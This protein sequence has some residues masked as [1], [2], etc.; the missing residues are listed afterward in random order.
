MSQLLVNLAF[1]PTKPTGHAIYA[2]NLLPA[3]KSLNP[4]LLTPQT[5]P[6]FT[7]QAIPAD[8]NPD[9]GTKGHFKRLL[10]EQFRLPR[11]YR[12]LR[13]TLLFSPIPEAPLFSRCR[14]VV[15]LH[16]L[17]PLRFPRKS[18]LT[19]YFRYYIPQV[20]K[21]AQ[22]VLCDSQAT[23]EDAMHYYQMPAQKFSVVPL[24]YDMQHFQPL[25]LPLQNYFL[26]IGRHDAY[27]NLERSLAAFATLPNDY[28][29]WI[30][31]PPDP[32]Y[33]P[34]LHQ[35]VAELGLGDRVKFLSYV[36]YRD[37]PQLINQ[38][39][40][41]V[42][43]SLWE[44]FGLP[45][46][47]GMA[48]GTPV[49]TSNLSS[50]PEVAG[51]GAMLVDPYSVD[52]IAAVMRLVAAQPKLRQEFVDKGIVRANQFRWEKTSQLALQILQ[53]YL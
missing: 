52:A 3:L 25:D 9:F 5:L 48:C 6:D 18:P 49:I 10:W 17:I 38:A 13:S 50:M 2:K 35:Q 26:Y 46:L 30:A 27:K 4:I 28:E 41:L 8:L 42:F 24:A 1:I 44:G 7:C 11:L 32:R 20:L 34:L 36:P 39:I 45:V 51:D 29:F 40:A 22:H 15:T 47:E 14:S 37:L 16:D 53:Q 21:Q 12:K 33:T 19:T 23:V 31:G 43:V